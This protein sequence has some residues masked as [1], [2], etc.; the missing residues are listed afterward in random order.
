MD[1][2]ALPRLIL[3]GRGVSFVSFGGQYGY[4][5]ILKVSTLWRLSLIH[6]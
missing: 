4:D 2:T 5:S 3:I 1:M 6:I